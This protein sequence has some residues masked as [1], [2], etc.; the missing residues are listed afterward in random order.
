MRL[1]NNSRIISEDDIILSDGKSTL[2]DNIQSIKQDISSLKSNVKWIYKYGGVGSGSGG[3]G[4]VVTKEFSIYATLDGNQLKDQNITLDGIGNHELFVKINN[5]NGYQY[6]V[7][8]T[9]TT[10]TANGNTVQQKK[11]QILSIQNNYQFTVNLN[12]NNNASLVIVASNGETTQQVSCNYITQPYIFDVYV[13]DDQGTEYE[14]SNDSYEIFIESARNKGINIKIQYNI[15]ITADITYTYQFGPYEAQQGK[16]E[17]K[18]NSI[19]FPIDKDLFQESNAGLYNMHFDVDV[20]PEGQ[21]KI[22][23]S[24]SVGISLIP[25]ALYALVLPETGTIY[26]EEKEDPYIYNP[27]Y[28][29]FNYRV[30]EGVNEGRSY[31]IDVYLN[32]SHIEQQSVTERQQN[33]FRIFTTKAG[34]NKLKVSVQRQTKYEATYYFYVAEQLLKLDWF[35]DMSKWKQCYYRIDDC[36]DQFSKYKNN[37]YIQQTV[38]QSKIDISGIEIPDV[39]A[40]S[41]LNTHIAIGY[42]YN[43]IN[44]DNPVI[45]NFYNND[46]NPVLIINQQQATRGSSVNYYI[47]QEYDTDATQASKYHLLQIYSKY[48]KSLNNNTWYEVSLYIDGVLEAVFPSLSNQAL[49]VR[50]ME[51]LP[52]NGFVN[53][54]DIDYKEANDTKG[55]CDLD[56]YQYYLKYKSQILREDI[57]K[58][59]MV[60][61]SLSNFYVGLN[62]RVTTNY[63]TINNVASMVSTPTL[64]LTYQNPDAND[65]FIERLERNYGEDGT[66]VGADLSFPV[67]VQWSNG[68]A[69]LTEIQLPEGYDTAQFKAAL[70]GSSTKLYRVKNFNLS[71]E[72]TDE[73]DTADTYL[74]SPNFSNSDSS[75]FLPESTFTLKADVVDSSHSNNTSCGKFINTVCRKFSDDIDDSSI[76][77][78]YV[79]NCLEG[80]PVLLF[81]CI[82]STDP[83]TQN[84][85]EDYYY[86]GVYNFNLGRS[87][88]FNLGYKDLD[89][90]GDSTTLQDSGDSFTFYK[91]SHE[92][93]TI[94]EGMGVA[95]IQ[96]GSNY[97]DFSQ[98]DSS[99]LFEQEMIGDAKDQ[100]Y[101]FGDLVH[102]ANFT[103]TQLKQKIQDFVKSV[104]LGGGY[105]FD[106]LKKNKGDYSDGYHAEKIVD[107]QYTGESLNQVPNYCN[108]YKRQMTSTG[109]WEYVKKDEQVT[110]SEEE[111]RK[112]VIT[113]TDNGIPAKMN[114][115]SLSE[116][117]TICMVLG[118]VDSVMKNLN[119]KTWTG[120]NPS[121]TTWY[122]A[123]YDMDT[124][125]GINNKGGA[126]NYFAFSDYW[127]GKILKTEDGVEYPSNVQI[128]RD[129]SPKSLGDNGFDVPC[130]YLFAVAKYAR[131]QYLEDDQYTVWYPQELYAKWRSN[132]INTQ[133][134]EGVL[135]NADYF[136]DNFYSNN[137][138]S[139][140]SLLITYNYRSKYLSLGDNAQSL[141]WVSTDYEKFNGTR[142]NQVRD[143]MQGRLHILDAYFNLNPSM[144]TNF[145]YLNGD[146]WET[147]TQEGAVVMDLQ[148]KGKYSVQSNSDVVILRDIFSSGTS[149]AGLQLTG[150]ASFQIKCPPFSPLQIYNANG[151]IRNNY[152]IG[153]DNYQNISFSTTGNQLIKLGGSQAWTYLSDINWVNAGGSSLYM[154]SDKLQNIYGSSG[155]FG[156]IQLELPNVKTIQLN[157]K[158]YSG[159]LQIEGTSNYPNLNYI[160]LSGS[161]LGL[162][163]NGTNTQTVDVSKI[164]NNQA[165]VTISNCNT[166]TDF[167]I[168]GS[169]LKS[170]KWTGITGKYKNLTLSG[171]AISNIS[172]SCIEDGGTFKITNDNSLEQLTVTGFNTIIISGCN[173]LKKVTI[174]EYEKQYV[175]DLQITSCTNPNLQVGTSSFESNSINVSALKHLQNFNINS[176][177]TVKCVYLPAGISGKFSN[178]LQLS[179]V[180]CSQLYVEANTFYNCNNYSMKNK[181]GGRTGLVVKDSTTSIYRAFYGNAT[182]YDDVYWFFNN[183]ISE[184]NSLENIREVF[185]AC[186]NISYSLSNYQNDLKNNRLL[187][188]SKLTKVT[189][190]SSLFGYT[191]FNVLF[192]ELLSFGS[193]SG[194]DYDICNNISEGNIEIDCLKYC[195]NKIRYISFQNHLYPIQNGVRYQDG[196]TVSIKDIFNPDGIAPSKLVTIENFNIVSTI[197]QDLQ[198]AFTKDFTSLNNITYSFRSAKFA[199]LDQAL[200]NIPNLKSIES[201][202]LKV[203]NYNTDKIDLFKFI[204]WQR[205][206][207][208]GGT[209]TSWNNY[210]Y[211]F[212]FD[213]YILYSDYMSL[214][215]MFLNSNVTSV[216]N[217]F[218]NTGIIGIEGELTFGDTSIINKKIQR[219]R[220]LYNSVYYMLDYDSDIKMPIKIG[221]NMFK[222]L[223][224]VND[225]TSMF[226]GTEIDSNIPFDFFNKR[227]NSAQ[228]KK[229]YVKKDEEYVPG[230]LYEYDYNRQ[231]N[232]FEGI[233]KDCTFTTGNQQCVTFDLP[234]NRA[235][236][237]DGNVYSEYY[238]TYIQNGKTTYKLQ[239]VAPCI[240]YEDCLNLTG[241]Y[242]ASVYCGNGYI[243]NASIDASSIDVNK[244]IIPSDFFY[245]ATNSHNEEWHDGGITNYQY[246]FNCNES[247]RVGIIPQNI[248][249]NCKNA[250][251]AGVFQNQAVI[252]KLVWTKTDN[253]KTT[254]LYAQYPTEYCTR[255]ILDL[256]FTSLPMALQNEDDV[257]NYSVV[258]LQDTISQNTNQMQY[259]FSYSKQLGDPIAG[260]GNYEL[261]AIGKVV[262]DQVVLG[263]DMK[264]FQ[265]LYMDNLYGR[266]GITEM[267]K[268]NMFNTEFDAAKCK[269]QQYCVLGYGRSRNL[270]YPKATGSIYKFMSNPTHAG[271]NASQITDSSTSIQW[272]K[273]AGVNV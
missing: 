141:S 142:I 264:Y 109:D 166:I 118:L 14:T 19:I 6:N 263:F 56:V 102:G 222:N 68:N 169:T 189:N 197:I 84:K 269:I 114:Y 5:P 206:I 163:L 171:T 26:Q 23:T 61:D 236:D 265:N 32:D 272:Y 178:C 143:W 49:F 147:L 218:C 18:N 225:V 227:Y 29:S 239:Q 271:I 76:Y 92:N 13:V 119:I 35:D 215:N 31:I 259:A 168:S 123:F 28:I 209:V 181:A 174:L 175:K 9:Y 243:Y 48:V 54:I 81:F 152:I 255:A 89:V 3:G 153:G 78:K 88:Y 135:K 165:E 53:C 150:D 104:A 156:S 99:I 202:F 234:I 244:L 103:E 33:K 177:T 161:R 122:A 162:E 201:S 70:Q 240:E 196:S 199:N 164:S 120:T 40:D 42:Q 242:T 204:N 187:N 220:N 82:V 226:A 195:I 188:L 25:K 252:P 63:S 94:R 213:K 39:S 241:V 151:V 125:L 111:L 254:N 228:G 117:Y 75:T 132:T 105:L 192:K 208:N 80:F 249:K 10:K 83:E 268:G 69:P 145:Q 36:S 47:K 139:V 183:A 224:A 112:L 91:L 248:F 253:N 257:T 212:N 245:C 44:Q 270:I 216:S 52:I 77:K 167:N 146:K 221:K 93:D 148:Y 232:R 58:Q 38:N 60:K 207:A 12:L 106:Y 133:T 267:G 90:L 140:N 217:L 45:F 72:N 59:L 155:S 110:G 30:Y 108:Q 50:R 179:T 57:T 154:K 121:G 37:T 230:T 138:G 186:S 87:S 113:D 247:S 238:I 173:S 98:Y 210:N 16:I 190:A 256:A 184:N 107:G 158:N 262:N 191:S 251:A 85:V 266:T 62:G 43:Y 97:F 261:N 51:I 233:F 194:C 136:I 214:C 211:C 130:S 17:D 159:S 67:S 200:Y 100:T 101:M 193:D 129:F 116:Y 64:L 170:F 24:Q 73:S 203:D 8:Y 127:D 219:T 4:S 176:C 46:S 22:Q 41:G 198:G 66:G 86:F 137:L 7:Q 95:E 237:E 258:I 11:T 15:S 134:N 55:N 1:N 223:Q 185:N 160:N 128:Y 273:A 34:L 205:Y 20:I 231:I 260:G 21:E 229:I 250:F 246:A 74:Y 96:G 71:I 115:Q 149:S 124:C 27:G 79:R 180:D 131:T 144:I 126:I 2:S 182:T 65:S 157:S 172:V 235:E